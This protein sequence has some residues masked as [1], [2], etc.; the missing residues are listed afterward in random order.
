[1]SIPINSISNPRFKLEVLSKPDIERIHTATLDIIETAGVKFPL[2]RALN[3]LEEHGASVDRATSIAK[4]PAKAIMNALKS[5]PPA[6]T[7]AARDPVQDLLMDGRHV[8]L[9]TDGC[10]V[11]VM[12]LESGACTAPP[13]RMSPA[14]HWWQTRWTRWASGGRWLRAGLPPES[15]GLHELEAAWT[16]T[17]KHLQTESLL[18]PGEMKAAVEMASAIAGGRDA[19]RK[20][21]LLSIIA[22]HHQPAGA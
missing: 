16:N 15:R 19:L 4:I 13:R 22:V 14:R 7:L 21:P 6:Y 1:M 20:R 18:Q 5:A 10:G 3:I 17:T 11:Q 9:G 8:F 2:P 12:D